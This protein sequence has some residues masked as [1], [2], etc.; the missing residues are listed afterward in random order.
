MSS[1]ERARLAYDTFRLG[2]KVAVAIPPW[3]AAPPWV[4]DVVTVAYLQGKLDTP[5]SADVL[6]TALRRIA[7]LD[8]KNVAKYARDIARTASHTNVARVA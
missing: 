7:S 4:R 3:D 2:F 6:V 8:E 1:T 5:P